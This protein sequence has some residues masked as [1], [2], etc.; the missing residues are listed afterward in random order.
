[1]RGD[2]GTIKRKLIG[3]DLD[4]YERYPK[5]FGDV[6]RTIERFDDIDKITGNDR[7]YGGVGRDILHGQ[8]GADRIFGQAGDDNIFGDLGSDFLSG[9]DGHDVVLAEPG[10][11]VPVFNSD[12]TPFINVDGS[13][14][15][16]VILEERGVI[17]DYL[18]GGID[19]ETAFTNGLAER[20]LRADLILIAGI[21][22]SVR[23]PWDTLLILVNFIEAS[24]NEIDG[25]RGND[26]LFGGSASDLIFGNDGND[27]LFGGLGND[28]LR[29]GDD[30]DLIVGDDATNASLRG[31]L[32]RILRGVRL[33]GDMATTAFGIELGPDGTLVVP[34]ALTRPEMLECATTGAL[35]AKVLTGAPAGLSDPLVRTDGTTLTVTLGVHG[36]LEHHSGQAPGN[37]VIDGGDGDDVLI[38]DHLTIAQ[39]VSVVE[40]I[41]IA[42]AALQAEVNRWIVGYARLSAESDL[43]GA[44]SGGIRRFHPGRAVSSGND[45]IRG[46]HGEDLFTGDHVT[47]TDVDTVLAIDEKAFVA[48]NLLTRKLLEDLTHLSSDL[49]NLVTQARKSVLAAVSVEMLPITLHELSLGNDVIDAKVRAR[50]FGDRDPD[51]IAGGD[52]TYLD[53]AE[54]APLTPEMLAAVV[55]ALSN[56]SIASTHSLAPAVLAAADQQTADVVASTCDPAGSLDRLATDSD[57]IV[58][59]APALAPVASPLAPLVSDED[60][61]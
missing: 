24:S 38:G 45:S 28:I 39:A 40:E 26:L 51:A 36:S 60:E 29:G 3:L 58:L 7:I 55:G 25:G 22:R 8:R 16:D 6:V 37:D 1:V 4:T 46:G 30:D 13:W 5:P 19:F 35:L 31:Y 57:D 23:T 54:A 18:N 12:G 15:R 50:V 9:G 44:T 59:A 53:I 34:Q 33:V 2:N 14:R 49:A 42:T 20:L 41:V 27:Q 11:I 43:A 32:S 56:R 48:E 21:A 10:Q 61:G 47:L 52:T 17:V